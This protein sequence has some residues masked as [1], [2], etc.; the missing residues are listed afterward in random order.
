MDQIAPTLLDQG[1]WGLVLLFFFLIFGP[2]KI[3]SKDTA[4]ND[5]WLIGRIRQA[6]QNRK[7][8]EIENTAR[9]EESVISS[10]RKSIEQ[11]GSTH[12]EQI[13]LL[14]AANDAK[15]ASLELRISSLDSGIEEAKKNALR[16]RLRSEKQFRYILWITEWARDVTVTHLR[17]GW[18]PDIRPWLT[19][20]QWEEQVDSHKEG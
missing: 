11:M 20:E 18:E 3:L 7:R 15:V 13:A 6:I 8:A 19:M 5:L 14:K 10:L 4:S 17:H 16:E 9:L 2:W 12:A 1:G